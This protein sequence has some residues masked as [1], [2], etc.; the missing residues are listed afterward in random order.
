MKLKSSVAA[1]SLAWLLTAAPAAAAD[2]LYKLDRSVT[3]PSTDTGWDYIKMQPGS[4]RLFI[5]RD[6]DA[7][8]VFDVDTGK[9]VAT[10]DN[11]VGAN[12]PLLLPEYDRG[13]VAMTDGSLLSFELSTLKPVSR[14]PLST[15]GGLNSVVYDP[16]TKRIHA[17]E[18]TRT[19]QA[20]W[21]TL[22][23]VSGKLLSQKVFPFRKMDDPAAD[24]KG[25]LFAPA[26]LDGIIMKLDSTTLAEQARWPVDCNVSKVSYQA[27]SQRIFAACVGD[28]PQFLVLDANT[29]GVLARVPVGHGLDGIAIDPVRRRVVTS[30]G[31]DGSLSVIG[32]TGEGD[33]HL[34]GTISTRTGARMM[35]MDE[36]TGRLYVV[37]ADYTQTPKDT[38]G[39]TSK[40]Y[41]SNSFVVLTYAPTH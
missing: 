39:N 11:S 37:S 38:E 41:H 8:T 10:V 2:V 12:G 26:R 25:H 36:R 28:K 33:F 24:G 16:S 15:T 32:Q 40:R 34:L 22:D 4:S 3:L 19:K 14:Q 1:I 6:K 13:Y 20:T 35:T 27:D 7:L 21:F 31:T 5:A 9:V 30:N 29:G 17:I 23:P 18:G